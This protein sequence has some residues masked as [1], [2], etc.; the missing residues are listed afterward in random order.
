MKMLL[1]LVSKMT[2]LLQPSIIFFDGAEKIFYKKV[3]KPEKHLDPKRIGKKLLKGIVKTIKPEDRVMVLGITGQ[4][5]LAKPAKLKKTFER[6]NLTE[7]CIF[8]NCRFNFQIIL[9]PRPDY[10]TIYLYWR[11][12]LMP[13]H[14]VNRD[15][16][17]SALA[18]VTKYYPL[19]CI[20][21]VVE[22]I[23]TPRR[24]VELYQKPLTQ[25][26]L[27]EVLINTEPISDKEM[28]KFM[29]F[30]KKTALGK[31]RTIYNKLA[32]I[33]RE[34]EAKAMEKQKKQQQ[35]K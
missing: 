15:F 34:Q 23:F 21:H 12:L 14:G 32:E 10:G 26:E 31:E 30:L 19:P 4:P 8:F 18:K 27:Y 6:V 33:K 2:R 25:A 24:I 5:W 16:D 11:Q 22:T 13:F 28:N 17:A 29:K 1:H 35:K 20:K 3:P 7:A 9:I